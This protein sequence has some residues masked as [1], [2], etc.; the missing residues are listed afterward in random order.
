MDKVLIRIVRNHVAG[1]FYGQVHLG[2]KSVQDFCQLAYVIWRIM[3]YPERQVP[4]CQF[5]QH[6]VEL[7]DALMKRLVLH[8]I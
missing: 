8:D 6:A 2:C 1:L 3:V 7:P 4:R 5:E